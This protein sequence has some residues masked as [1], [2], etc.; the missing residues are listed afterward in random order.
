MTP[1]IEAKITCYLN[2]ENRLYQDWYKGLSETQ[3]SQYSQEVAKIPSL[4]ELKA[5]S[6]GWVKKNSSL[7]KD[8]LC[9]LYCEKRQQLFGQEALLIGLIADALPLISPNIPINS[10][11]VSVILVTRYSLENLCDCSS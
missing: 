6:E 9:P 2:D 3:G 10:I 1:E 8:K 5:L 4:Q 11:A 7:L